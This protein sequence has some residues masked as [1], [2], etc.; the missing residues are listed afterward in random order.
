MGDDKNKNL[1][2]YVDS[3][4]FKTLCCSTNLLHNYKA[5]LSEPIECAGNEILK[6]T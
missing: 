2:M 5:V 3:G 6:Y 4:A 1:E